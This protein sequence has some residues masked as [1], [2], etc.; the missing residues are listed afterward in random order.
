MERLASLAEAEG[1]SVGEFD[2]VYRVHDYHLQQ[3][4][5]SERRPFTGTAADIASD[6][7]QFKGLGVT[8]LVIDFT[9][10]SQTLD[11]VL[12]QMEAFA[13]QVWPLVD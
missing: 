3:D 13:T 5:D 2:I 12:T 10:G 7:R 6:I 9:S 11:D 1:R 4:G 8:H